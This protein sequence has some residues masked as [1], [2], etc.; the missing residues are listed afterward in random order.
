MPDIK[1]QISSI[2]YQVWYIKYEILSIEYQVNADSQCWHHTWFY[3]SLIYLPLD[4]LSCLNGVATHD[5]IYSRN[6]WVLQKFGHPTP[7][8]PPP[9]KKWRVCYLVLPCPALAPDEDGLHL[10]GHA[11][12]AARGRPDYPQLQGNPCMGGHSPSHTVSRVRKVIIVSWGGV[13]VG[14]ADVWFCKSCNWSWLNFAF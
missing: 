12:L 11:D 4:D 9:K 7:L 5:F 6:L 10:R 14:R 8:P 3:C 2:R 1:Y 13:E